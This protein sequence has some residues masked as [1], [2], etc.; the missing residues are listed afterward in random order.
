MKNLKG[1]ARNLAHL[2]PRHSLGSIFHPVGRSAATPPV[3]GLRRSSADFPAAAEPVLSTTSN[4]P[5]A[6]SEPSPSPNGSHV[7]TLK[8]FRTRRPYTKLM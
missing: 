3:P 2:G 5:L 4:A 6:I 1:I 8:T 7:G